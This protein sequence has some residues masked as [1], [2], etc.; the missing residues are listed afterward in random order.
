[1]FSNIPTYIF[2]LMCDFEIKYDD[3]HIKLNVKSMLGKYENP[4]IALYF[5]NVGM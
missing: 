3:V 4:W 5:K 1:M 2:I